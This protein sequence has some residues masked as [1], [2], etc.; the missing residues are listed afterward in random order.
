MI[1]YYLKTF[2]R[3]LSAMRWRMK[4]G[5]CKKSLGEKNPDK[6]VYVIRRNNPRVG[7][8][9]YVSTVLGHIHYARKKGYVPVVDMM[10]YPNSYL[11]PE[12]VGKENSWEYYFK[13]PAG[14]SLQDAYQSK[15]V[16]FAGN[17]PWERPTSEP[18]M[19]RQKSFIRKQWRRYVQ[20]NIHLS[21]TV[22]TRTEEARKRLF[23]EG[24]RILGI[25]CRGT[26]FLA[27]HPKGHPVQP[28]IEDVIAKAWEVIRAYKIDKVFIATEDRS[29]EEVF[30]KEF[31]NM[32]IISEQTRREYDGIHF[33]SQMRGTRE[34]DQYLDGLEYLTTILLL[35]KCN[36]FLSG[37]NGGAMGVELFTDGFEYE[38]IWDL[39]TYK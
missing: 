2:G 19:F 37:R 13:Q 36:C 21:D 33:I 31:G 17:D 3:F 27:L 29:I 39:G 15:N 7:L 22:I 9:S 4:Y 12:K 18:V 24:A 32:L 14:I 30:E 11:A 1:S 16:V 8:F 20:N 5:I 6:T 35:A 23:P 25:K 34:N 38:Y 28:E 26:D 10:N